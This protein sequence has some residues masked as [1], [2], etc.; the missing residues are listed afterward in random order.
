MPYNPNKHGRADY[1]SFM[2]LTSSQVSTMVEGVDNLPLTAQKFAHLTYQVNPSPISFSGDI[3]L[4]AVEIKDALGNMASVTPVGEL[5]VI[6][7]TVAEAIAKL[8]GAM[9]NLVAPSYS[10]IV[11]VVGDYTYHMQALPSNG[12]K[13]SGDAVWQVSRTRSDVS[14]NVEMMYADGNTLFDNIAANYLSLTYRF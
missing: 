7:E 9:E 11:R 2:Q 4:G 6:D 3:T 10:H 8:S 5:Y 1:G 14:G 13:T 12:V